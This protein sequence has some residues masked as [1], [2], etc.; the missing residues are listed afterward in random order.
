MRGRWD[1]IVVGAG[2]AGLPTTIFAA[3]R[4]ARVLLAEQSSRLGGTLHVSWAQMSAGGT[5]LQAERGI[6][7]S[8]DLHF[9]DVMR[10]S[11][12]TA[13]AE[14]VRLAVTESPRTID[15]LQEQGF[16][17]HPACPA[18][19]YFHEAYSV[20]RTYWGVEGGRSVLKVLAPLVAAVQEAGKGE[21]RYATRLVDLLQEGDGS[22]SGVT[23]VGPD[24]TAYQELASNVVL[25]TGGYAGN[26][27]L[28]ARFTPGYP[29][30][31]PA[32]E[33]STGTGIVIAEK[34][35]GVIRGGELFLPTF[36]G[37]PDPIAPHRSVP[38]D[39]YP[40]LTPQVRPPWEVYVNPA[41]RRFV[42]EDCESIDARERALL[43]QPDLS[44]WIIFD[45][46]VRREAPPLLPT[47]SSERVEQ[48]FRAGGAFIRAASL[49]ALAQAAGIPAAPLLETIAAYN[50]ACHHGDDPLGRRFF[51]CPIAEPPF[52]AIRNHGTTLKTP[53]GIAVDTSLRVIRRDGSPIGNL[54]AAGEILGGSTLSGN[55]FVGGMSVTPA[56]GFG[57]LLGE[58][59][60]EW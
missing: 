43:Q 48:A 19:V 20:P 22:V 25:T 47:W 18:L 52:Y 49:P 44:F 46:R 41:G 36:G 56:I 1:V 13:N 37:I 11:K 34:A 5:R 40:V 4:G 54:Y 60:L 50:A 58:R 3:Q 42:A 39:D 51:P 57:R 12:G 33:T 17:F 27:E 8:P 53:A 30:M 21:V 6:A 26:P 55:A 2:T 15:W 29:L 23:L 59:L 10:I 38:L 16:D 32:P 31:S 24:G 35:G 45:E 9:Q 7:D 14:L 28:F